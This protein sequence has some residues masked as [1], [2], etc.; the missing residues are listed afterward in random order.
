VPCLPNAAQDIVAA[1]KSNLFQIGQHHLCCFGSAW[2][3]CDAAMAAGKR[4]TRAEGLVTIG[5]EEVSTL[6]VWRWSGHA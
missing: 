3:A 1:V 5:L 4:I 2:H 6:H